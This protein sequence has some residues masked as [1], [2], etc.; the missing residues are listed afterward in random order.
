MDITESA[1]EIYDKN[2]VFSEP[3]QKE[4][5]VMIAAVDEVVEKAIKALL[6]MICFSVKGRSSL[7]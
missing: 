3:A 6:R 2:I 1:Q 5:D 7:K 4:L